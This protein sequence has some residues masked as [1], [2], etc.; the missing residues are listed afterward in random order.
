V[1]GL[2]IFFV[3]WR[4]EK[5]AEKIRN[6]KSEIR[7]KNLVPA[8]LYYYRLNFFYHRVYIHQNKSQL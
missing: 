1:A 6:Q 2:W 3:R 5:W 4:G 7:S 8:C